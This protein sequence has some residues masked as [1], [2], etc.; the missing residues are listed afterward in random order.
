MARKSS[1]KKPAAKG[2]FLLRKTGRR[3][4]TTGNARSGKSFVTTA[5]KKKGFVQHIYNQG[6]KR[7]VVLVKKKGAKASPSPASGG[8]KFKRAPK[9]TKA[10]GQFSK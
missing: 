9:G 5:S 1:G 7:V 10:G 6:G 4:N 3:K 2:K 8:R